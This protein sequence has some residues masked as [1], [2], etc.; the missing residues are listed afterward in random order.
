MKRYVLGFAFDASLENVALI[1][2]NR[3]DWQAGH[4][5]GIGGKVEE[6]EDD[7]NAMIR[8]FR[9]ETG[10]YI[11]QW[12]AIC[13]MGNRQWEVAVY[14]SYY[15]DLT[16]LQSLTDEEV[17]VYSVND[18][19]IGK[20]KIISNLKWLIALCLD[21]DTIHYKIFPGMIEYSES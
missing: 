2:K 4:L 8:E 14:A 1:R 3:P 5:N 20:E 15:A 18:I 19:L 7:I 13:D 21:P 17:S 12:D 11:K 9:E 16:N 10:V 6:G